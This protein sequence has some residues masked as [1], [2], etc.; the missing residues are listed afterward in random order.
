[1]ESA[2]A[3]LREIAWYTGV[4]DIIFWNDAMLSKSNDKII[5]EKRFE[6]TK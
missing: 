3:R 6:I 4:R 1:M 5:R 2:F